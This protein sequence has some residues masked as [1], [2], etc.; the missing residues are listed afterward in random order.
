M[1]N[2]KKVE[3]A[4]FLWGK[5]RQS[6]IA[7]WI[8][9]A[10]CPD[11][12]SESTFLSRLKVKSR[13]ELAKLCFPDNLCLELYWICCITSDYY[14]DYPKTF[15]EI[16]IPTWL[17]PLFGSHSQIEP[18][19][20]I[21]PPPIFHDRHERQAF[22]R[23][24]LIGLSLLNMDRRGMRLLGIKE[25]DWPSLFLPPHHELYQVLNEFKGAPKTLGKRGRPPLNSDRLAVMCAAWKD[26]QHM[27]DEDI[28]SKIDMELF[29]KG[30]HQDHWADINHLIKRGRKLISDLS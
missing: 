13:P 16:R 6:I 29:D 23:Y 9:W 12:P 5:W 20:R 4:L 8:E 17:P 11:T 1:H 14:F 10:K 27:R 26:R 15:K 22:Q 3:Q 28:A 24:G 21:Y 19:V 30:I 25:E 18:G 7:L 2:Y